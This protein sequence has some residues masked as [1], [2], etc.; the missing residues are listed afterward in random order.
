VTLALSAFYYLEAFAYFNFRA[1][2]SLT[3]FLLA[4]AA[5]LR[6]ISIFLVN[7]ADLTFKSLSAFLEESDYFLALASSFFF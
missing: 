1:L 7:A 2:T 5:V 6:D 3:S 4:P